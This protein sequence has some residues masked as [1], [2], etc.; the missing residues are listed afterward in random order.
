MTPRRR[1]FCFRIEN[2]HL[3]N[4]PETSSASKEVKGTVGQDILGV[5]E[6]SRP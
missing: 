6:T 2:L 5:P 4:S 1:S 3:L